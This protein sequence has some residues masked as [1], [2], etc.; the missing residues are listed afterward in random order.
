MKGS[1]E[2]LRIIAEACKTKMDEAFE[3]I[4]DL[5]NSA[6]LDINIKMKVSK[7]PD[8]NRAR[9]ITSQRIVAEHI[10]YL[11]EIDMDTF[12][13]K[14]KEVIDKIISDGNIL[15]DDIDA[16]VDMI[17]DKLDEEDDEESDDGPADDEDDLSDVYGEA[18]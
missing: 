7:D 12:D 11:S 17:N 16:Y 9:I 1:R 14:E 4:T 15:I 13:S 18:E 8:V 2:S 3:I 5:C 6:P 10:K